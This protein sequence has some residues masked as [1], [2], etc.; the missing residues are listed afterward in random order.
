M[1]LGLAGAVCA[2][3]RSQPRLEGND[4][5]LIPEAPEFW[6]TRDSM[7]MTSPLRVESTSVTL[8]MKRAGGQCGGLPL[9]R[10]SPV[11]AS[12]L[13]AVAGAG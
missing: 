12:D 2:D 8:T 6:S 9:S 3:E 13:S 5:P 4:S 1:A 11:C 10:L 7:Y